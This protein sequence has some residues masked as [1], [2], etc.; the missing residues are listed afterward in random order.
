MQDRVNINIKKLTRL[1]LHRVHKDIHF[2]LQYVSRT[3]RQHVRYKAFH[4]EF[5]HRPYTDLQWLAQDVRYL[6]EHCEYRLKVW[7]SFFFFFWLLFIEPSLLFEY[8]V[9]I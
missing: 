2:S 6:H 1:Y 8:V 4:D 9:H 3:Y 7:F 5:L